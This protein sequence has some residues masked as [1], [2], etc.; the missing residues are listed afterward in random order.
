MP[1]PHLLRLLRHISQPSRQKPRPNAP[2]LHPILLQLVIPV[3]HQHI[4]RRLAAAVSDRLKLDV[5]G[6]A[7]RLRRRGEVRHACLRH[8]GETGHEDQ[9]GV[10]GFEQEGHE[11]P[12]QDVRAGYVDIVGLVEALAERDVAGD[13]F[14]V[15]GGS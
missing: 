9:A 10:G 11:G 1:S 8:L 12:G 4:Q 5:L 2:H 14:E 6:P 13:E 7:G 3:Q 15:K